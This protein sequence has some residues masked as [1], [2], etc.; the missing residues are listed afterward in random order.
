MSLSVRMASRSRGSQEELG[1]AAEQALVYSCALV[2][3][4]SG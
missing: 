4:A 2:A 1:E 3:L